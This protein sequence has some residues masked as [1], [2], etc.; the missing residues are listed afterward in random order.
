MTSVHLIT[1]E[2]HVE[3]SHTFQ[4]GVTPRTKQ[5]KQTT[6]D[7]NMYYIYSKKIQLDNRS[8]Q[9]SN[10]RISSENKS[11]KVSGIKHA[12]T[13]PYNTA[14]SEVGVPLVYTSR[15]HTASTGEYLHFRYLKCLV[16]K[17]AAIK[18]GLAPQ[19]LDSHSSGF[20]WCHRI[21]H[22]PWGSSRNKKVGIPFEINIPPY[23]QPNKVCLMHQ[24]T[25]DTHTHTNPK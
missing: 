1:M 2:L 10:P 7:I 11:P 23:H 16:N 25:K 18:T 3:I 8:V 22:Y 12:G 15:I 24:P 19:W 21:T 20:S 4:C 17:Q 14:I 5:A 9:Y 13:E 6:Y